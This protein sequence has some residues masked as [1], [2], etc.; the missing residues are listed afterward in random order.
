M[1]KEKSS[2]RFHFGNGGDVNVNAG[3][4]IVGGDKTT[5]TTTTRTI[6]NGFAADE[7]K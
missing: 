7:Q 4:D 1:T 6:Q 5:T 2:G 3:A